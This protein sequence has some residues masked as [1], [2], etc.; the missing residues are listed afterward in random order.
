VA[1]EAFPV[2][3]ERRVAP[4]ALAPSADAA[5][6]P[7]AEARTLPLLRLVWTDPSGAGS[8]LE[9]LA[10]KE[11]VGLLRKMGVPVTWRR[12]D[13]RELA[14]E[15]ELRII[16]LDQTVA[17]AP[18]LT[19]LGATPA[20]FAVSPFV[21]V[22]LP[23]VRASL[24]LARG[25]RPSSEI[26]ATRWLAVAVGRVIAHEVVHAIAPAVPHGTGLM[27]ATL[28]RRQLTGRSIVFDPEVALAVREALRGGLPSPRPDDGILAAAT[29]ATQERER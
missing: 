17:R 2:D 25:R 26:L 9:P 3:L 16:L 21:W 20:A 4:R 5:L 8:G 10:R 24:G 23:G 19:V 11:A 1:E 7:S 27:S 13:A 22:H 14:R 28:T 12:G 15:G 18:G 6:A 29:A